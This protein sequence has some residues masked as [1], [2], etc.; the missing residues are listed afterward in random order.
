MIDKDAVHW[1]ALELSRAEGITYDD[2]GGRI[3]ATAALADG[4][5]RTP[6]FETLLRLQAR[7]ITARSPNF[8][9][10]YSV[11]LATMADERAAAERNLDAQLAAIR[12]KREASAAPSTALRP[13]APVTPIR[14]RRSSAELIEGL[15]AAMTI[16]MNNPRLISTDAEA[17]EM[18]GALLQYVQQSCGV[19]ADR[20]RS[21]VHAF[22]GFCRSKSEHA[23]TNA[24]AYTYRVTHA[25]EQSLGGGNEAA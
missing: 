1:Q 5:P 15:R 9:N 18:E 14:K 21:D 10:Q 8:G 6:H 23:R 3:Y 20:V 12:R 16:A 2:A 25:V 17:A 22:V 13:L 24:D 4:T 7:G 11:E 19:P